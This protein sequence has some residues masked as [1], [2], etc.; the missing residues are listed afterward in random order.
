[1]N[2]IVLDPGKF[3]RVFFTDGQPIDFKVKANDS[4]SGSILCEKKAGETFYLDTM[5]PFE[6]IIEIE[7]W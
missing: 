2:D 6:K 3:Y 5:R 4:T 1:M 7:S